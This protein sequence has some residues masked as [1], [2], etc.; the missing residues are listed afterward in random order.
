MA[1]GEAITGPR[2]VLIADTALQRDVLGKTLV[3]N[4][5]QLVLSV[6]PADLDEAELAACN[7]ELWL[8]DIAQ[9]A[10]WPTLDGLLERLDL[11]LLYGDGS[12]PEVGSA[13]YLAWERQLLVK[14]KKMLADPD[15]ALDSSLDALMEDAPRPARLELPAALAAMPLQVGVPADRVWLLMG[16]LGAPAAVRAFLDG[17]PGGLPV[18]L[19]YAQHAAA[20]QVEGEFENYLAQAVGRY[21]QWQVGPARPGDTLRCGEVVVVP[22]GYE[23]GIDANGVMQVGEHGWPAPHS[24]S[25]E[26]LMLELAG[27]FG[28]RF[29][30]IA[31][32]GLGSDGRAACAHVLRQRGRVWTQHALA[33]GE[34]DFLPANL[35]EAA[36]E[37]F[38]GTPRE[39]AEALVQHLVETLT[40]ENPK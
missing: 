26:Q 23:W 11:P 19:V 22:A 10:G 6:D 9:D 18:G 40:E 8:L 7:A 3:A 24:P 14:L 35:R 28:S 5:Y 33:D 1:D 16:G 30:V 32:S 2:V 17:L 21:S 27:R 25:F 12:A 4:G 39:L 20:G 29:G 36:P 13:H 34:F 31:F 38:S 15:S 37:G